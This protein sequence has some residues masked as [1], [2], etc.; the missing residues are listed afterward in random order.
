M[1]APRFK[2]LNVVWEL[3]D[4]WCETDHIAGALEEAEK[5]LATPYERERPRF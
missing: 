3:P 5:Y 4:T 1:T 2:R